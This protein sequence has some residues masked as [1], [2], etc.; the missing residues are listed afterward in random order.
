MN[1][2]H[3][4]ESFSIDPDFFVFAGSLIEG[5]AKAGMIFEVPV[6]GHKWRIVVKAIEFV[7]KRGGESFLGLRVQNANYLAGLGVGLTAELREPNT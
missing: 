1:R 2:F 7:D 5:E 4:K 3:I 6:P